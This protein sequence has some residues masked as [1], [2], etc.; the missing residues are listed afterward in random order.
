[1][2]CDV[3]RPGLT[4]YLVFDEA[5]PEAGG[6]AVGGVGGEERRAVERLVDVLD[7]DERLADGAAVAVEEH[8]HLLVHGVVV[9]QQLAL[10]AQVLLLDEL[11][12]N[13]LEAERRLRAVAERAVEEADHLYGGAAAHFCLLSPAVVVV[14]RDLLCWLMALATRWAGQWGCC[15]L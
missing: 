2:N 6:G 4:V 13:S 9:Q 12:G 7:D 8:G 1:M 11:V 5:G 3:N 14:D 15:Y 10:V